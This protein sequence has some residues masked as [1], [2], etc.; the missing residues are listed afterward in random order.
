ME[1]WVIYIAVVIILE[2]LVSIV[3]YNLLHSLYKNPETPSIIAS[4]FFLP[5]F[6]VSLFLGF[7]IT[8]FWVIILSIISGLLL[9]ASSYLY[10][11]CYAKKI[12]PGTTLWIWKIQMVFVFIVGIFFL[13]E[14]LTYYQYVGHGIIF[15]WALLLSLNHFS[16]IQNKYYLLIPLC[17]ACTSALSLIINDL[18]YVW[19]DFI[20]VFG[21]F[22]F[23]FFLWAPILLA[24]TKGGKSF[25]KNIHKN[26]KKYFFA[27]SIVESLNIASV[28]FL[29]LALKF[30]P[31]SLVVFLKET[32]VAVLLIASFVFWYFYPKYFPDGWKSF[33]LYKLC[34]IICMM[35]GVYLVI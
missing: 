21:S 9:F 20:T 3:D 26:W 19:N 6:L 5:V 11:I 31:L 28:V 22:A 7:Q 14:S 10:S 12:S 2:A 16:D 33:S 23:G 15:L 24:F 35:W 25:W 17:G 13:W 1:I 34:I 29:N 4:L 8:D 18:L 30:G 32:Y 27:W